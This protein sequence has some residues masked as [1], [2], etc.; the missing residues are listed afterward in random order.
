MADL[1]RKR[2]RDRLKPRREPY[3][4][5]LE[6]GA[7]LGFRRG[8]DT[9]VARFRGRDRKQQYQS[10][11]EALEYDE[12]KRRAEDW[13]SQLAGSPVRT[14]KRG[15][16]IAALTAYLTDL[17]RHDRA[18]AAKTADG[19]FKTALGFDRKTESYTDPLAHLQLEQATRDDF[20]DWRDRLRPGRLPRTINRLVRAVVAGLNRA[21]ALGHI[22]NAAAWRLEG[23][24][25]DDESETAVFLE[26]VQ[27]DALIHAA[28]PDAAAF[29]RGLEHSGARPKELAS[30]LAADFDGERLKLSHR[31]GRPPKLRLRYVVLDADAIAFF[32]SHANGKRPTAPLFSDNGKPWRR[33]RWAE[34]VR[35]AI[36]KHNE[37]V[38][39]QARIPTDASAYSF[40]HARISELLQV[41]GVD[42]LTVAAQ[43]GTSLRM[44][45]R[46]YFKFI[47][48]AMLAKLANL[49][50]APAE[51]APV[52]GHQD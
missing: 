43:T 37:A 23:L 22:G 18:D 24:S 32:K 3:W 2:D 38:D 50:R 27:R 39:E 16:V 4:Q 1:S 41:Y 17:R 29:V 21:N 45:E 34:E 33:D 20:Q 46:T 47:R 5:R 26:P 12:A 19:R 6:E 44:I 10:L 11:G 30:A 8:P 48:S 28:T 52:T 36:A 13:L 9:W 14:V 7:Y 40:R 31:K 35:A 51:N 25:D 49:K 15:T 42:P